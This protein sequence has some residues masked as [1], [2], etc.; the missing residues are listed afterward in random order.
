[1]IDDGWSEVQGRKLYGMD[2][3]PVKFPRGLAHTIEALKRQ[4]GIR[5]V[6]VWHTIAGYWNGIHPDSGMARELREYLY[7]TRRGNVIPH[8]DA[9]RGFGFWHAWHGY[10]AR[11]GVD[12]VKVDSQSAVHNFL[13][14]HLPVGQ[15]ASAAH[16]ALEASAA[17]HFDRTIINCMGM[18]AE[19]IW[20]RPVS[21]VSRNSDDFVPQ[22][23]HG[24]REHAL[25]NA[26]NSYYH[27][28]GTGEIGTCSG[29]IIT[30]M[31]GTWRSGRSAAVPFISAM[32]PAE[33]I[34]PR[35]CPL[36]IATAK[37]SAATG[38]PAR[39]LTA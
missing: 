36:S 28:A 26:Y 17:L 23:R 1:M 35:S 25:Q 39:R 11:Q 9:G 12:F 8:P 15:A 29:R 37:S 10:L 19:N 16:T 6:G 13:R 34:R 20:H 27:G 18:S 24:F 3:D 4:Y 33:R 14:H 5:W 7:V 30:T 32:R 22:E 38:R 2:A 31:C 21:A